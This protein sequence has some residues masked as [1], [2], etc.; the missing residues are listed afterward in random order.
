MAGGQRTSCRSVSTSIWAKDAG[1]LE[2]EVVS[3]AAIAS[4]Q[5]RVAAEEKVRSF[6]LGYW[7]S[8]CAFGLMKQTDLK[9]SQTG[10]AGS[11]RPASGLSALLVILM[12]LIYCNI[13]RWFLI[14]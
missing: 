11:L 9:C 4:Q 5:S 2:D 14:I 13:L 6:P 8:V 1:D 7:P 12:A 3:D 10:A